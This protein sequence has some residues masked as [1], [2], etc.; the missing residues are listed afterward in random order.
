MLLLANGFNRTKVA[1][2]GLEKVSKPKAANLHGRRQAEREVDQIVVQEWK[3]HCCPR[4]V[5][6][7]SDFGQVTVCQRE[8]PVIDQHPIDDRLRCAALIN[9]ALKVSRLADVYTVK[10]HRCEHGTGAKMLK[11][12]IGSHTVRH[13]KSS[14]LDIPDSLSEPRDRAR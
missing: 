6:G 8:A 7:A 13:R 5:R 4:K 2:S 12:V 1:K 10:K 9:L 14:L 3:A 11:Q